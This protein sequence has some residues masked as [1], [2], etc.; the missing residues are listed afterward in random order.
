MVTD[1]CQD[2]PFTIVGWIANTI[3]GQLIVSRVDIVL[4]VTQ[5]ITSST[6]VASIGNDRSGLLPFHGMHPVQSWVPLIWFTEAKNSNTAR[7][8]AAG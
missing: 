8:K 6:P 3:V 4:S 7:L 5:D 2:G 1:V